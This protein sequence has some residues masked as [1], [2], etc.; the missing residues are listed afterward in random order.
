MQRVGVESAPLWRIEWWR[1]RYEG[2]GLAEHF[3]RVIRV[4]SRA[5]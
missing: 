4:G 5:A 3:I 1:Q 2:V